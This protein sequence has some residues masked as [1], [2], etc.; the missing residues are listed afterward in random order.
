MTKKS[1]NIVPAISAVA[2]RPLVTRACPLPGT[3]L[4]NAIASTAQMVPVNPSRPRPPSSTRPIASGTTAAVTAV[5]GET[6][7]IAPSDRPR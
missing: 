2:T 1:P 6:T 5:T 7:D 4:I 3:T